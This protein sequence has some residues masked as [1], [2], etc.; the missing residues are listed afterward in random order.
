MAKNSSSHRQDSLVG[1]KKLTL[2]CRA[3]DC[4]YCSI[5]MTSPAL[6]GSLH[7]HKDSFFISC[8]STELGKCFGT[9]LQSF[10]VLQHTRGLYST[11]KRARHTRQDHRSQSAA[12]PGTDDSGQKFNCSIH[13][14]T[15]NN[16]DKSARSVCLDRWKDVP[17]VGKN[18]RYRR[19]GPGIH[20]T[21]ILQNYCTVFPPT[22]LCDLPCCHDPYARVRMHHTLTHLHDRGGCLHEGRPKG[23]RNLFRPA[24]QQPHQSPQKNQ[25]HGSV[26]ILSA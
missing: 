3:T 15:T 6:N 21:Q 24:P 8:S 16:P 1:A 13:Q 17:N 22:D 23:T 19:R 18:N 9:R 10:G 4:R 20:R 11:T 25:R 26:P 5:Q 12:F 14:N 2:L 7:P